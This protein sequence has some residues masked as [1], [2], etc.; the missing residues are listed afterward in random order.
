MVVKWV[1][2]CGQAELVV[3]ELERSWALHKTRVAATQMQQARGA[4]A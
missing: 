4:S 1:R 2:L 3:R